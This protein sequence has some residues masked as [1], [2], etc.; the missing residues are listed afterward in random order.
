MKNR[1]RKTGEHDRSG[2]VHVRGAREHNLKNVDVEIPRDALVVFTGVSGS[3]KSSL[4]F[5][6][7]YA[8]AQRRY[9]ESVSP[10]ARRLFDQMPVPEV[11]EIDGL[12]PAVALAAAARLAD[13]ALVGRQRHHALEPAAHA[14]FAR[15]TLSARPAASRRRGVLAEHAGGRLPAL[16]RA[17]PRLRRD[18][19]L[20]GARR[21]ADHPRARHRRLAAGV[22][23]PEPARH[24][25]HA[26]L[27]RR[28]AVARAAEERPRLD[29]VH[30]RAAAGAGLL[31]ASTRDEARRALKRKEPPSYQGT[32]TSAQ[33]LRAAD[34]RHHAER[35][36]EEAR[37]AVHGQHRLPA[38]PRQAA[39]A[40]VAV[41]HVRGPRH[42]RALAPA[43]RATGRSCCAR[44]AIAATARTSA[45]DRAPGKGARGRSASRRISSRGS[46]CCSISASAISRSIAARRRSRR[47]SCSG[48]AWRRRCAP[49]CSAS[50]TCSTSRRPG[51]IRPTP[52]RCCARSIGL[53]A[54][55]N[56]LF[57]VEHE[58]DVI[59]HADWIVDVGPAAG[60]QGGRVLYSGPPAGLQQVSESH[61]RGYLFG[62]ASAAASCAATAERLAAPRGRHAQQSCMG[63]TSTSR[64]ASSPP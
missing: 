33:A 39:A 2:F 55:G 61:T 45:C 12:P 18:R 34:L 15:R 47:A 44:I 7:L 58:L 5:G 46:R 32:F 48:C 37:G 38:L 21:L 59:R 54:A 26:R 25:R 50:S 9:L 57:V 28:S 22:A 40:R 62:A 63:S 20:D 19:A 42:R 43:A 16:P 4:A 11:D 56:S 17:R 41:G 31:P 29:P 6:T 35:D 52:R 1:E 3:G 30:R 13:H 49:T 36:D 10:Y 14:L 24:P 60:E 8:E 53:K 23:R 27:R 64:S 51:C